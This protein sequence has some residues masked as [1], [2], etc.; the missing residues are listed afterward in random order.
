MVSGDGNHVM[1]TSLASNLVEGDDNGCHD[2]FVRDLVAGTTECVS[3]SASGV[4]GDADSEGGALTSDGRYGVFVSYGSNLGPKDLNR[5]SDVYLWDRAGRVMEL[6]SANVSGESGNGPSGGPSISDD[7][8]WVSFYSYATDLVEGGVGNERQAYLLDR[9][10]RKLRRVSDVVGA[11]PESYQ[12]RSALVSKDGQWLGL[13]ASVACGTG[14]RVVSQVFA[15][16]MAGGWLGRVSAMRSGEWGSEFSH[17]LQFAGFG[18][19]LAFESWAPNLLGEPGYA[20]GQI[21]V[22]DLARPGVDALV[23]A[24][25]EGGWRGGGAGTPGTAPAAVILAPSNATGAVG[26]FSVRIQNKGNAPDRFRLRVESPSDIEVRVQ[27]V[28]GST[29]DVGGSGRLRVWETPV[30]RPGAA[31]DVKVSVEFASSVGGDWNVAIEVESESDASRRDWVRVTAARDSDLDGM[32]DSWEMR[33]FGGLGIAGVGTDGDGDG[34]SD[35]MEWRT[36]TD[37]TRPGDALR[38]GIGRSPS[39]GR[40]RLTWRAK[41]GYRYR[42]ERS[43]RASGDFS[44]VVPIPLE[45]TDGEMSWDEVDGDGGSGSRFYR[46]GVENP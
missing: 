27:W 33:F 43:A 22:A 17:P 41:S 32:P 42:I 44:V 15:Y 23:R 10:N 24:E 35:G 40:I 16:D 38:L 1:F 30:V 25:D 9:V 34:A 37:P 6:I 18:R 8:R 5:T 28:G 4:L 26:T 45:G 19:Y 31:L 36:N 21:F 13:S 29:A 39:E 12:V 14:G 46:L 7:G 11:L 3:R 2:V 20:A